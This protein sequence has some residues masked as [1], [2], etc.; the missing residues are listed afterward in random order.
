MSSILG[1]PEWWC[2]TTVASGIICYGARDVSTDVPVGSGNAFQVRQR[3]DW[4]LLPSDGAQGYNG[5]PEFT[6]WQQLA[7]ITGLC[8]L[9]ARPCAGRG[10]LR[11]PRA[12]QLLWGLA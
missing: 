4:L 11:S 8:P 5:Q 9:C 12:M 7:V 1:K 3:G 10:S 2:Q 6:M